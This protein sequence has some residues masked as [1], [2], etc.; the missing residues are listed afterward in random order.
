[1]P[2]ACAMTMVTGARKYHCMAY[3]TRAERME[4]MSLLKASAYMAGL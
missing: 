1:M 2:M 3:T 4:G